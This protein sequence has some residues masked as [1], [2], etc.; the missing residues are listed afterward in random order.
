V[1]RGGRGVGEAGATHR[2]YLHRMVDDNAT[3]FRNAL[4]SLAK[5][6]T[7]GSEVSADLNMMREGQPMAYIGEGSML[8]TSKRIYDTDFISMITCGL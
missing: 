8:A 5:A 1:R 2:I 3:Y 6:S 7:E 4:T